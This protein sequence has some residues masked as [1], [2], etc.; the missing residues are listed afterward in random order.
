MSR[1]TSTGGDDR[2]HVYQAAD[3][4]SRT[5]RESLPEQFQAKVQWRSEGA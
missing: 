5:I 3:L 2:V 4:G 1:K